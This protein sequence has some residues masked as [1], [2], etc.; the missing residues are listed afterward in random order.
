V[1]I[2]PRLLPDLPADVRGDAEMMKPF[3]Q[4]PTGDQ[5]FDEAQWESYRRL[6]EESMRRLLEACPK[7][8]T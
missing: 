8:L 1:W 5:F 4:Q 2:K 6:G 3:P 7:L